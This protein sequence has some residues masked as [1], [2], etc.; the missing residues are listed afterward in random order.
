MMTLGG[1]KETNN[2][3]KITPKGNKSTD[4]LERIKNIK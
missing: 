2:A 1:F 3:Q 4:G